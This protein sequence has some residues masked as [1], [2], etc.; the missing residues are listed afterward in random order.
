MWE[1][2]PGKT[3]GID[4]DTAREVQGK[5]NNLLIEGRAAWSF[6][7]ETDKQVKSSP[8]NESLQGA[9]RNGEG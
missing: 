3:R 1:R 4:R 9:K 6:T 7:L 2:R 8:E 5:Y